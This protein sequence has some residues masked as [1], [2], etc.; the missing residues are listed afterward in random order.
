[1]TSDPLSPVPSRDPR[2]WQRSREHRMLTG[3]CGGVA[4][5]FDLGPNSVRLVLV[6]LS[7]ITVGAGLMAYVVAY[8]L[9][10]GPDGEPAPLR[11]W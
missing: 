1:M 9:M 3:V 5:R 6:V 7:L 2:P 10:A 4:E 11:S 8:L